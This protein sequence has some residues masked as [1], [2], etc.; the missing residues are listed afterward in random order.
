MVVFE[1]MVRDVDTAWWGRYRRKLE[2]RLK[3]QRILVRL[4][5]VTVL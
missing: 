3:Q 2:R 1:V 4:Y 5:Q